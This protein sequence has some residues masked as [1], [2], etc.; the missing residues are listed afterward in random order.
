[1]RVWK[2]LQRNSIIWKAA[3]KSNDV[4]LA[5]LY[6]KALHWMS[7]PLMLNNE[8][9]TKRVHVYLPTYRYN[10]ENLGGVHWKYMGCPILSI[11]NAPWRVRMNISLGTRKVFNRPSNVSI[12][13]VSLQRFHQPFPLI[14]S[15]EF[16]YNIE[17]FRRVQWKYMGCPILSILNAPWLIHMN[18]NLS[19]L[20][21]WNRPLSAL[22][23]FFFSQHFHQP[24]PLIR[25]IEF[26]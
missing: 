18:M 6:T 17:N 22:S 8:W 12:S 9:A 15:I 14:R 20:E 26:L 23:V 21:V 10:I 13:I 24:F 1:M 2:E 3:N 7:H 25:L 5:L 19:A 16:L 11:F 4:K